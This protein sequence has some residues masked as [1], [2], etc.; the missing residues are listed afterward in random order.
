MKISF[1]GIFRAL[2][3]QV[4]ELEEKHNFDTSL[5]SFAT[6]DSTVDLTGTGAIY[7]LTREMALQLSVVIR[8]RTK[9]LAVVGQLPLKQYASDG[10][11]MQNSLWDYPFGSNMTRR[12]GVCHTVDDLFFDGEALWTVEKRVKRTGLPLEFR[13]WPY[14]TWR[15][16][17]DKQWYE[18]FDTDT[19]RHIVRS[20][21]DGVYFPGMD[22]GLLHLG[23][24]HAIVSGLR[25]QRALEQ[26]LDTP[27]PTGYLEPAEGEFSREEMIAILAAF[28][29]GRRERRIAISPRAVK[30][31]PV[32]I[33]TRD[34][35]VT[36][37]RGAAD[38]D[39]VRSTSG[40]ADEYGIPV[41]SRTYSNIVD[42]RTDFLRNDASRFYGPIE[43]RLSMPDIMRKGQRVKFDLAA[44]TRGSDEQRYSAYEVGMRVG[45]FQNINEVRASEGLP[46][47]TP[48]QLRKWEEKNGTKAPATQAEP[49]P[50]KEPSKDDESPEGKE[51]DDNAN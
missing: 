38:L 13:Y 45:V 44:Y 12:Q 37:G 15:Y 30:Y 20:R 42:T 25:A 8:A 17:K 23:G 1:D 19:D 33:T 26:A 16:V 34:R 18:C 51:S 11:L 49:E 21:A 24:S 6:V 48:A 22:E 28:E 50:A 46:L 31:N 14:N 40:T 47:L 3:Y 32:A 43:D 29:K 2:G 35:L 4:A 39:L 41:T 10:A 27:P 7:G 5:A 36:D 9:L